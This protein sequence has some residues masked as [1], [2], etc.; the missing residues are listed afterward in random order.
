MALLVQ[1]YGG[2]SVSGSKRIIEVARRIV[3]A[4]KEGHRVVVVVSAMGNTTDQLIKLANQIT[5][6]P[7]PR[8]LDLLLSTG[9]IVSCTLLA[10]ALRELGSEAISLS[11][12][13]AGIHTD[14]TFSSA[15]IESVDAQ[16]ILA[17]LE[18]GRIV[19]VAGF[20][21]ATADMETTTLGRGGS[22]TTAVALAAALNAQRCEIYTDVPGVF[23]ADPKIVPQARKLKDLGFEEMLE[24]ASYGAS[25]LHPR[26]VEL[27]AVY[28][29]PI[30]VASSF[31]N[32]E[33]TLIHGGE[34]MEIKNK[35][36]GV[37]YDLDVA[38]ITILGI[39]DRPGIAS[40]LFEPLA[41]AGISVDTIVQNASV[42]KVTDL[43]FTVSRQALA[44]AQ[45]I[46][47]PVAESLGSKGLVADAGLGKVSIIGMG[48][49]NSPGY[50]ARM[51]KVLY[52]AG[53]NIEMI[54]TSD[55]RITCLV[56]KSKVKEAV[57]ALHHA[58]YIEETE[59]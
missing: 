26:A 55:I 58:F 19:I 43:T 42:E 52:S 30:L 57:Q 6:E 29:I 48:M 56:T 32:E 10:M 36:S 44:E 20:Q 7:D 50:A 25:V 54:T 15:R 46:V 23:T 13:Q 22:D 21:G 39:P 18:K 38:K 59:G 35:L 41:Q 4:T 53:I 12:A 5:K 2:S 28:N 34:P 9:E 37:A 45:K 16:R 1:K 11:G 17:E 14:D 33:G 3:S 47:T 31:S 51:F 49:Q 27:G 40:S 8:E 24:L